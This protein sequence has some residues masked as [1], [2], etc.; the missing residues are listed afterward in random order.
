MTR[1]GR[2]SPLLGRGPA[3]V[4]ADEDGSADC[5]DCDDAEPASFPGNPE[6]FTSS[7]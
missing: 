7:Q 6:V 5:A 3:E 1:A 4:D 2:S